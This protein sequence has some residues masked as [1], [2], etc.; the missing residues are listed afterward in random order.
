MELEPIQR[1]RRDIKKAVSDGG[2][3]P[4]STNEARFL[5][6]AYYQMQENRKR[7]DNQIRAMTESG[8]PHE[9]LDW[10]TVQH[11]TVENQIK[12]VLDAYSDSQELGVWARSI[13]GIGPVIAAGLLAHID[14]TRAA[15]AGAIWRFAGLDPTMTWGKGEKRPW[16]ASL[17]TLC[18]KI[19]K[20]FVYVSGNPDSFYGAYYTERKAL[21][22]AKNEAGEYADFAADQLTK[23]K[24][25]K[26]TEA[27]KQYIQGRLPAG[28]IDAQARR[29]VVKLF[30]SHYHE[31]G[32]RLVLKQR[33]PVPF[34][35]EHLG[36][37]HKIPIPSQ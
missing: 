4:L 36:H 10:L 9:V 8:E 7:S 34:A 21:R 27:Y 1:L 31:V 2:E 17:K 22:V 6:D 13:I 18:W 19:G 25:K 12:R 32:Y 16:N 24:F 37:V 35:I 29:D 26:T 15:T 30:L 33:P 28:H 14:L 20:S 11:R 23:K 3:S 5:V